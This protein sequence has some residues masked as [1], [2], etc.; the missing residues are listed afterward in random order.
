MCSQQHRHCP[1]IPTW[2]VA[3]HSSRSK[4]SRAGGG[5]SLMA[6]GNTAGCKGGRGA[7]NWGWIRVNAC[8]FTP[9]LSY[10]AIA[11]V[12]R[13]LLCFWSLQQ[14]ANFTDCKLDDVTMHMYRIRRTDHLSIMVIFGLNLNQMQ[15]FIPA[16]VFAV[17][18]CTNATAKLLSKCRT[19]TQGQL[20]CI[21]PQEP[22]W[23]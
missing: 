4:S 17:L 13:T 18:M 21:L 15:A 23:C 10:N 20:G 11:C 2:S 6:G 8:F 5:G 19:M 12:Q 9:S 16:R 7:S 14:L 3:K 1:S 22:F